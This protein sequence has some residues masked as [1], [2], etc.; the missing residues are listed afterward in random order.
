MFDKIKKDIIKA[1][2]FH[3]QLPKPNPSLHRIKSDPGMLN[4]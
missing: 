2:E 4:H 1:N 3:G